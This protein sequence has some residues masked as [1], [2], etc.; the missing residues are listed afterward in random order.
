M[1]SAS[2]LHG[3]RE[4]RC[5]GPLRGGRVVAVAGDPSDPA[6]F[7]F[8]A[9]AGGV[10]KTTDA[11]ITWRAVSDG[12]FKTGS[13]GALEVAPADPNVI[14]A[15]MG[16]STIRL[17][18]SHGDGVYKSID[19]GVSWTHIGLAATRHIGKVRTDPRNA[20]IVFV[21]ALGHAFGDNPERGVFRSRDGGKTWQHV[22]HVSDKAG[23]VDLSIDQQNPRFV[24]AAFWETYRS[25]WQI[26]SGGP[27]SGLWMSSDG[28]T[29]WSNISG[30]PG[31]PQRIWG[32]V[33]VAASP[34][35]SGRVWALIEHQPEGGL[36]RSDDYGSTWEKVSGNQHLLSRAWYYIHLTADTTDAE[37][38]YVNNL[39]LWVS[40]DGGRNFSEIKT[41]HGDNHDL[42]I[43]PRN[44]RRMI[45]G[46]DG[47]ATISLNGAKTWSTIYN[48]PTAQFY[49]LAADN[50]T[51]YYVYGTQQDNSSLA[52][53][54]RTRSP[55]IRW[56][57]SFVAGSG[58]SGYIAVHP[59]NPAIVYIGAI[60]SS[61]GGGNCLQRFDRRTNQLRLVT[62]WP[63]MMRG[64]GTRALK[65]RFA[66]TY[67]ILISAH[68]PE[69]ITIGGNQVWRSTDEGQSW[70]PISPDLT[71]NDPTT[72]EPSGGPINRDAVSAEIYGT[73][74]ALAESPLQAGL[75]W[76]GSDD[77]LV[78]ISQDDGA[79]WQ[80]ITPPDFAE[81]TLVSG[82]EPSP[83][84]A[85]T[86]Y[87]ACT[88]YKLDDPTP[89]LFKTSDY[90][91]SWTRI[92][93]G[94]PRDDFTRVI[95]A[96]PVRQ[97]LLFCGT[98][99]Q[100]YVS[101]DDGD[102]W[103][104]L[105]LNLPASPVYEILIKDNDLIV[106]THGRSIWIMDDITPLRE[107]PA[108]IDGAL[109][110]A[111]GAQIRP[112]IG[113]DFSSDGVGKNYALS[114]GGVFINHRTA[115][116]GLRRE[117]LDMGSNPP[118]GAVIAYHLPAPAA[119]LTLVISDAAGN[120]LRRFVS[121]KDDKD[122]KELRLP[123]NAG[124]NRFVWDTRSA[125][126]AK[127]K[128]SDPISEAEFVGPRV[129]PGTYALALH[130]D[131]TVVNGSVTLIS[132]PTI[133]TSQDDLAAQVALQTQV[134]QLIDRTVTA[135]NTMR[136]LRA[137]LA[138][139]EARAAGQAHLVERCKQLREQV[140]EIEKTL[141]VPDLRPGWGDAFT[142]GSRL[143]ERISSLPD[144][145]E[146]GDYKPTDAAI[147]VYHD[148]KGRI[149]TQLERL[150]DLK[151]EE[152]PTLN[153]ALA[154]AGFGIVA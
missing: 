18:V 95:R 11:G 118:K 103:Q 79:S 116:N 68:D 16:E 47:G 134:H 92:D 104:S 24:Y 13:V 148:L 44:N 33:A 1:T 19:G 84:D 62:T 83:F 112:L 101:F 123:N 133:G 107:L 69:K 129:V 125:S 30:R 9:A 48:Q 135:I 63:E 27:G 17:D 127:V 61:P 102:A 8:G 109:I 28:G 54:S 96:D 7:Y 21:A 147:E 152:L 51:P 154:A 77:G 140:L 90:G 6:T 99:T 32:K 111:A 108:V 29:N 78:H 60:G 67:P 105:Q 39:A 59:Q 55:G 76:A 25:F 149:E 70:Q 14:Y 31:L 137:Q 36:Y 15:G 138:G 73:V 119:Q 72:M 91:K 128:G 64:D 131:D 150:D 141:A 49:H 122:D 56:E 20:D 115:E 57:D 132:E 74:F 4:W 98:E 3:L 5:I 120:E 126:A 124:W 23:A 40:D 142:Y 136:D 151:A 22:L 43:D 2:D 41:P 145:I 65:Y 89:Y 143:L 93:A 121:K 85:G 94:I 146:L 71:K 80:N 37:R 144:V 42:W 75:F 10:F 130:V 58:E 86:C 100:V 153:A 82:L 113:V 106:G 110:S 88:R 50:N 81:W 66:W 117:N 46:N 52:T 53:P 38:V 35:R 139:W 34:A 114:T 12:Y 87:M 45:Q 97:G 26:S